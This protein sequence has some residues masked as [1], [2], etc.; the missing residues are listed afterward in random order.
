MHAAWWMDEPNTRGTYSLV[1]SCI[2]TL[3]LCVWT[4]VHLNI[5]ER[6]GGARQFFRKLGWLAIGLLAP[7]AVTFTAWNQFVGAKRL[8]NELNVGNR[9]KPRRSLWRRFMSKLSIDSPGYDALDLERTGTTTRVVGNEWSLV[10][11]FYA[12][13]GGY[14]IDT[15]NSSEQFLPHGMRRLTL[16]TDG[17]RFIMEHAPELIPHVSVADINDKSKAVLSKLL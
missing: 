10:H 8:V 17:L 2:F 12:M 6:G 5:P 1:S 9:Q 7:E 15:S 4:A 3:G 16:T 13:M 14:A 11:G